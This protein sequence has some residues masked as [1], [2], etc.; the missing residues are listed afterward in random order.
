LQR[1]GERCDVAASTP[2]VSAAAGTLVSL[3]AYDP[4][5]QAVLVRAE[6]D[7]DVI[8][9]MRTTLY[10]AG[11]CHITVD[12]RRYRVLPRMTGTAGLLYVP[13]TSGWADQFRGLT[14]APAAVQ[15]DHDATVS[16]T[17]VDVA[18]A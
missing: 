11:D 18:P 10:K 7:T 16:F 5:T 14:V 3:P 8:D 6:F 1:T 2:D 15:F 12:G 9:A 4:A 13:P 17:I